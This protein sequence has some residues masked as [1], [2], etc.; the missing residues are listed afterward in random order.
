VNAQ[1]SAAAEKPADAPIRRA[2]PRAKRPTIAPAHA[3]AK[4]KVSSN[5]PAL[6]TAKPTPSRIERLV[7]PATVSFWP[8]PYSRL[9]SRDP[10]GNVTTAH[11]SQMLITRPA[12]IITHCHSGRSAALSSSLAFV[13]MTGSRRTILVQYTGTVEYIEPLRLSQDLERAARRARAWERRLREGEGLEDDPF[14]LDRWVSSRE[15]FQRIAEMHADD[16]LRAPLRRWVYRMAELRIDGAALRR[17]AIE[18]RNTQRRIESP[19]HGM[20]TLSEV[21]RRALSEGPL[22]K[23]WMD[24][25]LRVAEPLSDVTAIL[26]ERR[27][28][29]ASRM[30]VP[31]VNEIEGLGTSA[32]KAAHEW[33]DKTRDAFAEHR[34]NGIAEWISSALGT[35]AG[36]FVARYVDGLVSGR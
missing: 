14:Y 34:T 29:V 20:R 36:T 9:A 2:G 23:A 33:L 3:H 17:V 6:T 12:P 30:G 11:G 7:S 28:E 26:W 16:P 1:S 18:Y 31:D 25:Y 27:K 32:E 35:D 4:A 15:T 21:L 10:K 19:E 13:W 22:R 8:T 24:A 5:G